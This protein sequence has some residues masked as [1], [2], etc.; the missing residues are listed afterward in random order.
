MSAPSSGRTVDIF[1]NLC[2]GLISI[3]KK[4][5]KR[6]FVNIL[7]IFIVYVILVLIYDKHMETGSVLNTILA[8]QKLNDLAEFDVVEIITVLLGQLNPRERDVV[9]RRYG[10]LDGDREILESIGKQHGLTRERIRQIEVSS[11]KK[12]RAMRDIEQIKKLRKIIILLMEEHGGL[13]EQE[14]LLKNLIHFSMK[15]T[16]DEKS[17]RIY[18]NFYSLLMSKILHE[19]FTEAGNSKH[20]LP[21]LRLNY[22][23]VDH[24]DEVAEAISLMLDERGTVLTTAEI[25]K[26]SQELD[27]Y[28]RHADKLKTDA[29]ID[30]SGLF[31]KK[32]FEE[33]A[34]VINLNKPIY[35][36]LKAARKIDQNIFGYWGPFDSPEIRPRNLN[37]KIYLVLKYSGKPLHFNEIAQKIDELEFDR[38]T[39]NVASAHNELILDKKYVL[40]GRGLYGLKEWGLKK[41]TV[42]DVI[43]E[44]LNEAEKPLSKEEIVERVLIKRQVKKTTILLALSNRGRFSRSDGRYLISSR[45]SDNVPITAEAE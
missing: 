32:R 43:T 14:Y 25:F 35:S 9:N 28:V 18:E 26:L 8:N 31:A 41:G 5:I 17:R 34:D 33:Q 22:R 7:T 36:A 11:I 20:L 27:A 1:F 10:L 15:D 38:K 45:V 40:V 3:S 29:T 2:Y 24:F 21:S 44:V 30:L 23:P 13:M 39:T 16:A 6:R 42:A 12:L 4:G 19:D 37:D